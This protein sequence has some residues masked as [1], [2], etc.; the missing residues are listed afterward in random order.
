MKNYLHN[1]SSD[2]IFPQPVSAHFTDSLERT[3]FQQLLFDEGAHLVDALVHEVALALGLVEAK[4][5]VRVRGRQVLR[6]LFGA[7][8]AAADAALQG[9]RRAQRRWRRSAQFGGAQVLFTGLHH[10]GF[11]LPVQDVFQAV[12]PTRRRPRHGGARRRCRLLLLDFSHSA[13]TELG[14]GGRTTFHVAQPE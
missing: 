4:G 7:G 12:R 8:G 9:R 10:G 13:W 3:Y 11:V 1:T 2:T 14:T 5:R 6:R